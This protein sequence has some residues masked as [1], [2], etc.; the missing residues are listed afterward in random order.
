[1]R[2]KN[3]MKTHA[4]FQSELSEVPPEKARF[5][6]IPAP[7]EA[8]VSYGTGTARGPLAILMASDQ[9]ELWDGLSI[10]AEEGICTWPEVDCRGPTEAVLARIEET[11][12]RVLTYK[13]LPFLLGGEH[14]VSLGALRALSRADSEKSGSRK[15]GIV[16]FDAHAD[17]REHYE[18]SRFSHA[19]VMRRAL[20]E[21][22]VPLFQIGVR[23]LCA[24]EEVWRT[25]NGIGRLDAAVIARNGIPERILPEEF[26]DR[27]YIS[28]DIDG[29]DPSAMPATGTPVPGGLTWRETLACL[30][31]CCV[32][33]TVIGADL[34]E[35]API[36][37]LHCADAT[38]AQLAYAMMGAICRN[39]RPNGQDRASTRNA[40]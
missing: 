2:A 24:E 12:D 15:F 29:L 31:R 26:P 20:E 4:F 21:L 17:L 18:G 10:P 19:C 36:Q 35:F 9:L 5:H 16:Q 7:F 23:A 13:G 11:V 6:V 40:P 39:A 8:S 14:T 28:F 1:M 33:R 22:D 38:A 25:A 27:V 34:V 32:G 30:E 3:T 37:G